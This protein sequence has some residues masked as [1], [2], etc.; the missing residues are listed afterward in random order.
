MKKIKL[1]PDCEGF[2]KLV[3]TLYIYFCH[4]VVDVLSKEKRNIWTKELCTIGITS[5][6]LSWREIS[7]SCVEA[8]NCCTIMSDSSI[9]LKNES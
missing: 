6:Y 8:V 9:E 1:S 2:D 7:K 5:K 4:Q 3:Q